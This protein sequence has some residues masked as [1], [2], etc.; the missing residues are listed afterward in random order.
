MGTVNL[1]DKFYDALCLK[2]CLSKIPPPAQRSQ[3]AG[4]FIGIEVCF[5]ATANSR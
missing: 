2:I 3:M 1:P 4:Y 5:G